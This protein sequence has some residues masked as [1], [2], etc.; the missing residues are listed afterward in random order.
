MNQQWLPVYISLLSPIATLVVVMV[1]FLY[2]N[3]RM[4]DL[5]DFVRG[6]VARMDGRINDLRDL[7]RA[8]MAKNHSEMLIKFAELDSRLSRIES[9][10]NLK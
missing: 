2:N 7:L 10:L 5:K 9:H 4:S 6:E 3:S 1:G 8:E